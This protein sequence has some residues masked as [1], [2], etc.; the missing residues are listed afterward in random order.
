V[1]KRKVIKLS[2]QEIIIR[3]DNKFTMQCYHTVSELR[4]H[5]IIISKGKAFSAK[6]NIF[7]A[8]PRAYHPG[9]IQCM[10]QAMT[11][12]HRFETVNL[13]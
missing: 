10:L 11:N 4:C 6:S 5:V 8:R 3:S 9:G 2:L 13:F 12:L 7:F 1:N